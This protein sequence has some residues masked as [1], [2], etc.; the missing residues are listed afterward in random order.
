[1][2]K[3]A[4]CPKCGSDELETVRIFRQTKCATDVLYV[5]FKWECAKILD[6]LQRC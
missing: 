6:S 2:S 5:Y 1:M 4:V 3:R